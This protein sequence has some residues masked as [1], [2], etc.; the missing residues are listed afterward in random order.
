MV[1]QTLQALQLCG[2]YLVIGHYSYYN[3]DTCPVS[4]AKW[5]GV[6]PLTVTALESAPAC[7]NTYTH[8]LNLA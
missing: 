1:G 7:S 2:V 8:F 4:Q 5:A 3:T 6:H